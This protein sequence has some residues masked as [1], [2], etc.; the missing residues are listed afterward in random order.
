[1]AIYGSSLA[2]SHT[3]DEQRVEWRRH[4]VRRGLP[5]VDPAIVLCFT[6]AYKRDGRG[7][8]EE[9]GI[10]HSLVTFVQ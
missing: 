7:K 6:R 2:A 9:R 5:Q 8:G 10:I 1:M 3:I 4:S